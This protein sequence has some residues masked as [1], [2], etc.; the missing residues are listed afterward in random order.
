M[1]GDSWLGLSVVLACMLLQALAAGAEGWFSSHP[2]ASRAPH[3]EVW[4]D[5]LLRLLRQA[6][7]RH[8]T[9]ALFQ[10]LSLGGYATALAF[11]ALKA[12]GSNRWA[13]ATLVA[14][15]LA[16]VFAIRWAAWNLASQH[17]QRAASLLTGPFIILA[18]VLAPLRK[19]LDLALARLLRVTVV[20]QK[21]MAVSAPEVPSILG[22]ASE[23]IQEE[24]REMIR[25]II[26][27]D[28][29]SVREVMVPRIDIFA[30]ED[31]TSLEEV[32]GL[33]VSEGY[34]RIPVY[35]KTID[36]IVGILYVKDLLKALHQRKI[37]LAL[38][39]I[40][41]PALFVPDS[42]KVDELLR[43]L[44]QS[45]VHLAIVV[46]EYGG[47]AGLVTIE[48]LLEEIVGEIQDEFDVEEPLLEEV[49]PSEVLADGRVSINDLNE[50]LGLE[51]KGQD[52]D[53]V[54]GLIQFHLSRF[55][56]PGDE[57][58]L[59]GVT[60]RVLSIVGKRVRKVKVQKAEVSSSGGQPQPSSE[61]SSLPSA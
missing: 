40:A 52:F 7:L 50:A 51:I 55:P 1:D 15:G 41:R 4:R 44:R 33:A 26:S 29:R 18:W 10:T 11:L 14:V 49:S 24:E 47:T 58:K 13:I 8:S 17:P 36:N 57:V 3:G 25:G 45:R 20:A 5:N 59:D 22:M 54:G 38:M 48:D 39:D 31:E 60:F 46:D 34:S 42:K 16:A 9:M 12:L 43:E 37:G 35:R 2:S 23:D 56:T 30:L 61:A 19:G 27:M 32:V 28:V 21:G 6:P 53:T